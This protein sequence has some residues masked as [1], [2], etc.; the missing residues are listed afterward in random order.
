MYSC[1]LLV[2]DDLGAEM[3]TRYTQAEV[4]DLVNARLN[5]ELPTIINTNLT[6]EEI[7]ER[8]TDRVLSRL[9]GAYTVV[10]FKGRDVR[11]KKRFEGRT[12]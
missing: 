8:Y 1:D 11:I 3:G 6:P 9:V 5:A 7:S 4:Y 2:V 12:K 10:A